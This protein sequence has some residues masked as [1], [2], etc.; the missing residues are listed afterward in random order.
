M[1]D[2][3]ASTLEYWETTDARQGGAV[4]SMS[5]K[6]VFILC[7]VNMPIGAKLSIRV[8]YPLRDSFDSFPAL[9]RI[10][11]KNLCCIGWEVYEYKLEFAAISEGDRPKLQNALTIHE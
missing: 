4:V 3:M 9:T 2:E 10:A 8:F 5:Q 1:N 7:H 11:G 6:G